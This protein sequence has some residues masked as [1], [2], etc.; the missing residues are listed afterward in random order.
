MARGYIGLGYST[1]YSVAIL[2][3]SKEVF[4]WGVEGTRWWTISR[5]RARR[6]RVWMQGAL[7][8]GRLDHTSP[9]VAFMQ[10]GTIGFSNKSSLSGLSWEELEGACTAYS[11]YVWHGPWNVDRDG[12]TVWMGITRDRRSG[13][14]IIIP[15]YMARLVYSIIM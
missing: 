12:H 10:A 1:R 8:S 4:H 11:M 2:E 9:V 7:S 6:A 14:L 3:G 13:C 5:P 15:S